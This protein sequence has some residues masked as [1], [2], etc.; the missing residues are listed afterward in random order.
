MSRDGRIR[1]A[2]RKGSIKSHRIERSAIKAMR[3]RSFLSALPSKAEHPQAR[4]YAGRTCRLQWK[5]WHDPLNPYRLRMSPADAR[6]L[7]DLIWS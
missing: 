4:H 1:S 7:I 3:Y 2:D 6:S 5:R